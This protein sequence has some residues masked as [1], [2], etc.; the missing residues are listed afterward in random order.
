MGNFEKL[1]VLV[2]AV[3]IVMILAVAIHTWTSDPAAPEVANA[4]VSPLDMPSSPPPPGESARDA[5][6]TFPD[7]WASWDTS[8]Q[9][10][11]KP[12][13]TPAAETPGAKSV[14]PPAE[15]S[16]TT[17]APPAK[18]EASEPLDRKVKVQRGDTLGLI[19][20][21]AYGTTRHWTRIAEA[22]HV[23]PERLQVGQ[24]LVIPHIEGAKTDAPGTRAVSPSSGSP[25]KGQSYTVRR[26]DTIQRIAKAAYGTVE[27]WPD[28]WFENMERI[29]DPS[30]LGTGIELRLPR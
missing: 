6:G 22:N 15:K 23:D 27:R 29:D 4:P 10:D 7:P 8:R 26:G 11:T 12:T 13:T 1:S 2:I 18:E 24:E 20:L 14:T 16:A 30:R 9:G 21:R 5:S 28:I 19:S 3:I 17:D 25:A